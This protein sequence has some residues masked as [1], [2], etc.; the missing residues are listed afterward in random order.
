VKGIVNESNTRQTCVAHRPHLLPFVEKLKLMS[1]EPDT[2]FVDDW[3]FGGEAEM[4]CRERKEKRLT[5]RTR[6][7]EINCHDKEVKVRAHHPM[8]NV[9]HLSISVSVHS[10]R[11][12]KPISSTTPH[13]AL[14]RPWR[15]KSN[16]NL[17]FVLPFTS[18][19][20][21][22]HRASIGSPNTPSSTTTMTT[23]VTG[24]PQRAGV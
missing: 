18:K 14:D 23:F 19:T 3:Q 20:R 6:R 11:K 8:I 7:D 1:W 22:F 16:K 4:M 15:K 2:F 12:R 24:S 9:T 21:S 5:R 17:R 10:R 13:D